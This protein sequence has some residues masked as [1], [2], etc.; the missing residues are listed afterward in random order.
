MWA[1]PQTLARGKLGPSTTKFVMDDQRTPPVV[2]LRPTA[3]A[4]GRQVSSKASR[5]ALLGTLPVPGIG[6]GV[7]RRGSLAINVGLPRLARL[8]GCLQPSPV[9]GRQA[10]AGRTGGLGLRRRETVPRSATATVMKAGGV[11]RGPHSCSPSIR[12]PLFLTLGL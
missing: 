8:C 12:C 4:V 3:P 2:R 10:P 6:S 1:T 5:T 9:A 7:G 11:A